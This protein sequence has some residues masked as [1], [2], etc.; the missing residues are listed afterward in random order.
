MITI[1]YTHQPSIQNKA[2]NFKD[3]DV[4]PAFLLQRIVPDS[5]QFWLGDQRL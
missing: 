2:C 3:K 4:D 5:G 1:L